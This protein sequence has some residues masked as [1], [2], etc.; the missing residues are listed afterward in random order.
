M[1]SNIL[2]VSNFSKERE[3][4]KNIKRIIQKWLHLIEKKKE[5][6]LCRKKA[7]QSNN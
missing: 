5:V 3:L 4:S 1:L 6:N 2:I 7:R